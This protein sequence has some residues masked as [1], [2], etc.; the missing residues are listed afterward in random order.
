MWPKTNI[1]RLQAPKPIRLRNCMIII[2]LIF[3]CL[4]SLTIF[5]T[6]INI[7]NNT[8]LLV[9]LSGISVFITSILFSI[10]L[11][12]YGLTEK[13]FK[14]GMNKKN[15]DKQWS[16]KSMQSLAMLNSVIITPQ[17]LSEDNL[18]KNKW[19]L[20]FAFHK[21]FSFNKINDQ[22]YIESHE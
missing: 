2:V 21:L 15:H 6:P 17:N 22:F 13:N 5:V 8:L 7:S 4:F 19:E 10:C 11:F 9:I 1:A 12:I 16:K 14:F 18:L 20:C 3:I